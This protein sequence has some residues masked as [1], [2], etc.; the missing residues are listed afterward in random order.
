MYWAIIRHVPYEGPGLIETV[1]RE[2][3]LSFALHCM[4]RGDRLPDAGSIAGLVVMGGPMGA[5]DEASHP[6]LAGEKTLIAEAVR[7]GLPV[8]GVCLGSQL[9]ASALGAVVRT[10]P[11]PEIGQG[12]V[13]LTEAGL[14][15]PVLGPEGASV[16]VFHWHGDTFDL[17]G[18]STHLAR[19]AL[20]PH[21]AFRA[22]ARAYALQVHVEVDEILARSWARRLPAGVGIDA[23][24]TETAGRRIITRFFR[25]AAG[26]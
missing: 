9:M 17:P 18:G 1:G 11:R 7:A 3:G 12:E 10:G 2:M 23:S 21:Q 14:A 13:Q 5:N 25:A 6:F 26:G 4:D 24:Q 15:D 20:Y 22:G 8:L 16:R 19:S